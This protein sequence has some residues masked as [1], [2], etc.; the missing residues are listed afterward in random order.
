MAR[1]KMIALLKK[2]TCIGLAAIILSAAALPSAALSVHAEDATTS[3]SSENTTPDSEGVTTPT[4]ENTDTDTE[5]DT[6]ES[7]PADTEASGETTPGSSGS[8]AINDQNATS[9]ASSSVRAQEIYPTEISLLKKNLELT[10]GDKAVLKVNGYSGNAT[11]KEVTWSSSDPSVASV[12]PNTG[13]VT[14][15]GEG[16][17]VITA[18]CVGKN[19][20]QA[21]PASDSCT[22]KVLG[23]SDVY[24]YTTSG[25][26]VTITDYLGTGGDIVIPSTIA[27]KPVTALGPMSFWVDDNITSVVIPEGVT[28]IGKQ[29]FNGDDNLAKITLPST[30][31]TIGQRAFYGTAITEI[32][33]P[34]GVTT[35]SNEAFNSCD[36]LSKVTLPSTLV[37]IGA[38][39]FSRCTSLKELTLPD[40]ITS[41]GTNAFKSV[42]KLWVKNG[43]KTE[44][45]LDRAGIEYLSQVTVTVTTEFYN[46]DGSLSDVKGGTNTYIRKEGASFNVSTAIYNRGWILESETVTGMEDTNP[47]LYKAEGII[48]KEDVTVKYVWR[49]DNIGP[50]GTSDK[51]PDQYQIQVSYDV[52]NGT[53]NDGTSETIGQVL[54]LTD[55]N[56][57]PTDKGTVKVEA[58]EVGNAPADGYTAGSWSPDLKD[59]FTIAD[60]GAQF[61]YS[62][63]E[64]TED[65]GTTDPEKPGTTPPGAGTNTGNQNP[66]PVSTPTSTK[67]ASKKSGSV[68][69]SDTSNAAL[70]AGLLL[71]SGSAIAGIEMKKRKK[72][73][74][75]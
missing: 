63:A 29:A 64:K 18:T 70:A 31:K 22:V 4:P 5:T 57:T 40:N 12:D 49:E 44:A 20:G 1:K 59:T 53:W 23:V 34:E 69:T 16:T 6:A 43:S 56:G 73:E 68:K 50:E 37:S 35:L 24:K 33:I 7:L 17:A 54:T 27:G 26:S 10:A 52:E 13:E 9:K 48:G 14:A 11:N 3:V 75:N 55:E 25:N 19:E 47:N 36:Q 15:V 74:E 21:A 39:A 71:L 51:I 28:T 32:T 38:N 66:A 8:A 62:Y 46:R 67:A 42:G 45:A 65:P 72:A 41:V 2:G 60:D 58:P 30:L 61:V